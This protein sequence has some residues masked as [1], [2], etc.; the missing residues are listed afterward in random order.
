MSILGDSGDLF[1]YD[2]LL[3]KLEQKTEWN[4]EILIYVKLIGWCTLIQEYIKSELVSKREQDLRGD[5]ECK[6]WERILQS[7][8]VKLFSIWE[9]R[10]R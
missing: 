9:A 2:L 8:G 7:W 4:I 5:S 1:S 10:I 6:E 3:W